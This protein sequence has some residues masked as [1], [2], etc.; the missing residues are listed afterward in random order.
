MDCS[1]TSAERIGSIP[2]G[3]AKNTRGEPSGVGDPNPKLD[4][5]FEHVSVHLNH[6]PGTTQGERGD[7]FARQERRW[8]VGGAGGVEAWCWVVMVGMTK[9]RM[10]RCRKTT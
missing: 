4:K 6:Y 2:N 9:G 5:R 3:A 1:I 10:R 8:G 7:G